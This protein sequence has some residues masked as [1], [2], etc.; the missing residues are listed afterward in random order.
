MQG[1]IEVSQNLACFVPILG[2]CGVK[3]GNLLTGENVSRASN[4]AFYAP[5]EEIQ[6]LVVA[7]AHHLE[8]IEFRLN[9]TQRIG[10]IAGA[11]FDSD[12]V[13][14]LRQMRYGIEFEFYTDARREVVENNRQVGFRRHIFKMFDDALLRWQ[15]VWRC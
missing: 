10:E 14:M 12:D 6:R 4:P 11:F 5:E 1:G 7:A 9:H 13:G 8:I 2:L 3:Q 15:A